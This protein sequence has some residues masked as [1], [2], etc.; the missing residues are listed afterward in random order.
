MKIA[1]I[2]GDSIC[3]LCSKDTIGESIGNVDDLVSNILKETGSTHYWMFLS[4]TPYFRH[5]VNPDYKGNR[6]PSNL[7]YLKTLKAYLR[8]QY[9]GM[10]FKGVEAD[11]MVAYAMNIPNT[12]ELISCAMDK[13]VIGQVP[14]NHLNY[15]TFEQVTT[16]VDQAVKFLYKQTLAGD[17]G[18]NIKGIPGIGPKKAE[19]ILL[20]QEYN[21]ASAVMQAYSEHFNNAGISV[22]EFQKNFRQVYLLRKEEDFNREVGYVPV[23]PDPRA[24]TEEDE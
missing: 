22:G 12:A 8:E 13:D 1:V 23:I 3:Y 15:R 9:G 18:D 24:Y 4:K 16:N 11:D 2:D 20:N 10:S 19:D 6:P 14:G 5:Q 7:K 17:S 21:Y